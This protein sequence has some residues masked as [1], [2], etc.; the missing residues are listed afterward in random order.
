[1]S[2]PTIEVGDTTDDVE[3]AHAAGIACVGAGSYK[4]TVDQLREA[5]ADYAITSLAEELPL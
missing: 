3:R 4:F 1:M 2:R 5:D